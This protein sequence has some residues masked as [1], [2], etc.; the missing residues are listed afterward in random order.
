MLEGEDR[1]DLL[2]I[3]CGAE[4]VL[5]PRALRESIRAYGVG[6]EVLDTGAACRTFNLLLPESRRVAA[7]LIAV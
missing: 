6:L 2:L 1:V 4:S 7:A 5:L 3:G